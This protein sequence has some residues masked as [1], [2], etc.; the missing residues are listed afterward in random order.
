MNDE[1]LFLPDDEKTY[2]LRPQKPVWN[3]LRFAGDRI[4]FSDRT[5]KVKGFTVKEFIDAFDK[6]VFVDP[7][8][9]KVTFEKKGST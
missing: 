8:G 4:E 5:V 1:K 6:L 2:L 3:T 7:D 9:K